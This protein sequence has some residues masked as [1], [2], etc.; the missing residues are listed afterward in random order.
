MAKLSYEKLVLILMV[1]CGLLLTRPYRAEGQ[2]GMIPAGRP[3][4]PFHPLNDPEY[5]IYWTCELTRVRCLFGFRP[6]AIQKNILTEIL[7]LRAEWADLQR[8]LL[9]IQQRAEN[10][11]RI[12]DYYWEQGKAGEFDDTQQYLE[13]LSREQDEIAEKIEAIQIKLTELTNRVYAEANEGS[14]QRRACEDGYRF[15]L[16]TAQT[17][18]GFE[19][20]I[21]LGKT[22]K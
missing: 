16:N 1:G 9:D 6:D 12:A 14:F 22:P 7:Q 4:I 3:P 18:K 5:D 8:I 21:G 19:N 11:K 10:F 13:S 15:C 20:F 2:I 17:I